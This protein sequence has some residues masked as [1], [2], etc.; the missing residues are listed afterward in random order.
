MGKLPQ[1]VAHPPPQHSSQDDQH[2]I[3]C[4]LNPIPFSMDEIPIW[5]DKPWWVLVHLDSGGVG[6]GIGLTLHSI[7]S[8]KLLKSQSVTRKGAF[9]YQGDNIKSPPPS[10]SS[11]RSI[12]DPGKKP[13]GLG[14]STIATVYGS[15]GGTGQFFSKTWDSLVFF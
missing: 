11:G 4:K 12:H 15:S 1:P 5:L 10:R 7:R 13:N 2:D 9:Q 3:E 6:N 14:D 8:S